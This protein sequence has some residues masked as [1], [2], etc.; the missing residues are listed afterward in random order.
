MVEGGAFWGRELQM[1]SINETEGKYKAH[2]V[3]QQVACKLFQKENNKI[4]PSSGL[5][6]LKQEFE[7][8]L[9]IPGQEFGHLCT[10]F[11]AEL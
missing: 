4:T 10:H 11:H 2:M 6:C 1:Q 8:I 5:V 3:V 7:A 9:G